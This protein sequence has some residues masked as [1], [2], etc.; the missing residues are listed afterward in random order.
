LIFN[1]SSSKSEVDVARLKPGSYYIV[2]Q[3]RV[4]RFI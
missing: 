3:E 4:A 1:L 2:D